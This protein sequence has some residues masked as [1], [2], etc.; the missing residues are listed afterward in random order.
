MEMN[1]CLLS[2]IIMKWV[3]TIVACGNAFNYFAKLEVL[4][5]KTLID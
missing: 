4:V 2:V 3:A 1:N 5:L